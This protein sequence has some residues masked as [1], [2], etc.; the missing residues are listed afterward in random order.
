MIAYQSVLAKSRFLGAL[1]AEFV[2][3]IIARMIHSAVRFD[4][5]IEAHRPVEAEKSVFSG[6]SDVL[7]WINDC[8]RMM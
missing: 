2:P 1:V 6:W 8:K 7:Q 5:G 3:V 4:V